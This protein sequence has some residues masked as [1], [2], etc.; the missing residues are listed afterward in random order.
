[1][2]EGRGRGFMIRSK[3][4]DEKKEGGFVRKEAELVCR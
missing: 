2:Y 4:R 1:M 3:N